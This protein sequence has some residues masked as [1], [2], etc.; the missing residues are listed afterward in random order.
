MISWKSVKEK[1]G[2]FSLNKINNWLNEELEK[3]PSEGLKHELFL[4]R[5][6]WIEKVKRKYIDPLLFPKK[7]N[8][9]ARIMKA[10]SDIWKKFKLLKNYK[11]HPDYKNMLIY[12]L[13]KYSNLTQ[14]EI[15]VK[16]NLPNNNAVSQR[17]FKFKR[18]L[19]M[20][21]KFKKL[22]EKIECG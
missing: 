2:M 11:H 6:S 7:F 9:K 15:A 1:L 18:G 3:S 20:N 14:S 12:I 13:W 19:K 4:G 5:A 16:F 21:K 17:L 8:Q 10:S 22:L